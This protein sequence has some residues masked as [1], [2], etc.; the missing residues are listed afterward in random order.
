MTIPILA[1]ILINSCIA[2]A[3]DTLPS[4]IEN[5]KF[6]GI[7]PVD[8]DNVV[9]ADTIAIIGQVNKE[10]VHEKAKAFFG[11]NKAAKYFFESENQDTGD[12][13]YQG[14]LNKGVMSKILNDGAMPKKSDVHFSIAIQ[15][16]DS[17]C[18]FKIYEVVLDLS[19]DQ[20]APV[21]S[22]YGGQTHIVGSV[23]TGTIE[24]A[25]SL[26]NIDIDKGEFSKRYCEKIND[27]FTSIMGDLKTALQ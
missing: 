13:V 24:G 11:R 17:L 9:Y 27:R 12:Q 3:H 15:F 18:Q 10:S 25:I 2:N 8:G 26:E 7:F 23:K 16:T 19:R 1:T 21:I 22:N 20:Y 14:V 4:H 5:G 6:Y